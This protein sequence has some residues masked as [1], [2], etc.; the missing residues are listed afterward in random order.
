MDRGSLLDVD[1]V[2]HGG[3]ADHDVLDFGAAVNPA[4]PTGVASVYESSLS[5]AKRLPMDDYAEFRTAAAER[6]VCEP[7]NVVP[8]AGVFDGLRQSMEVS[9]D[10]GD[11]VLMP[12]PACGEYDREVRLQGG[13]PEFVPTAAVLDADPEG[14]A[15]AIVDNPTDPTGRIRDPDALCAFAERCREAGTTLVVDERFLGFVDE[16]SVAGT[17]GTVAVHSVTNVYGLPGLRAGVVVATGDTRERLERA[18]GT[19]T[20][21]SPAAAVA[22][23]C[24]GEE[25]FRQRTVERVRAERPRLV[26]RLDSLGFDVVD[27][28]GPLVLFSM[29]GVGIEAV[30]AATRARDIAVRDARTYRGLDDHVRLTVR[31][32][33][34]ND[35]LIDAL[36]V[37]VHGDCPD[38]E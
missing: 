6:L 35:R 1:Q 3:T 22:T 26:D 34:E 17:P 25:E 32:P 23:H 21:S 2:A 24:L 13:T 11:S 33:T 27:G 20:I 28:E 9:V 8:V 37:A 14:H 18:R 12:V 15:A 5:A 10:P 36:G 31:R 29:G 19:Y 4:H 16:P 30:L 7:R 38:A